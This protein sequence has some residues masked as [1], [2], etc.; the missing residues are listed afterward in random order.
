MEKIVYVCEKENLRENLK[1]L[2]NMG[3][4]Y[5]VKASDKFLSGWGLS[6]GRKHI[7]LI[8]CYDGNE[9]E[10]VLKDLYNDNTLNYINWYRI[11]D[12]KGIYSATYNKTFTIR[13]D[14]AR[15]DGYIVRYLESE[16]E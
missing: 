8:A 4:K 12:Y 14:W 13:N 1:R 2:E 9:R 16:D 3:Y 15:T 6:S 7:E 10:L 5:I 11:N